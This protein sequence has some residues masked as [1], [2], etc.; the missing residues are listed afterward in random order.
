MREG[1]YPE[2]K[3]RCGGQ[4]AEGLLRSYGGQG[5]Q[6]KDRKVL[7]SEVEGVP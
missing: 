5:G 6:G 1:N 4:V 2:R 3:P 7:G